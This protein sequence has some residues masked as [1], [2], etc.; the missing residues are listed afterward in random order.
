MLWAM[1]YGFVVVCSTRTY[2]G[3]L[4]LGGARVGYRYVVVPD[5]YNNIISKPIKPPITAEK[6]HHLRK[7]WAGILG[8]QPLVQLITFSFGED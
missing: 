4:V 5:R 3:W 1:D 2:T 8:I 7:T 6:S